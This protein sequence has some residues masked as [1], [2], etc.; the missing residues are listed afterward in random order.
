MSVAMGPK[1]PSGPE[2]DSRPACGSR[3]RM[4]KELRDAAIAA[5]PATARLQTQ[6]MRQQEWIQDGTT[7]TSRCSS[8]AYPILNDERPAGNR[9]LF[10]FHLRKGGAHE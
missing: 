7:I 4:E 9:A 10:L 5:Q 6:R 1:S 3:N 2:T 8:I